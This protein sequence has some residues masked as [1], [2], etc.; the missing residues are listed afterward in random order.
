MGIAPPTEASYLN[1]AFVESAALVSSPKFRES[2]PLL[3]VTTSLPSCIA[4]NMCVRAGSPS[5]ILVGDTS[6]R[7][8]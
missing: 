7:Q 5:S 4:F 8:S 1:C 3:E 6:I 2:G